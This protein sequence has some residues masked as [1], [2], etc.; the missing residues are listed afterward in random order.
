MLDRSMRRVEHRNLSFCLS[1]CSRLPLI[2]SANATF[3]AP[4]T[5]TPF[6]RLLS[7][8]FYAGFLKES[9]SAGFADNA[10]LL[11]FLGEPPYHAFEAFTIIELYLGH[12]KSHSFSFRDTVSFTA[13]GSV[14]NKLKL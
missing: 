3:A 1:A 9:A 12:V 7:L 8:L 6:S 5:F 2:V 14:T 13:T 4:G 10:G 11:H